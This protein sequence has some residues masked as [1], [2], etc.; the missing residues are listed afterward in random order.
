MTDVSETWLEAVGFETTPLLPLVI[1]YGRRSQRKPI[2]DEFPEWIGF[3][4]SVGF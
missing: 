1:L 2:I 3:S 4:T